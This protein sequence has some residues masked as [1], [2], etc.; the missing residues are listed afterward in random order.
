MSGGPRNGSDEFPS[1]TAAGLYAAETNGNG[2][3]WCLVRWQ[4]GIWLYRSRFGFEA[5]ASSPIGNCLF[6]AL[7]E[8]LYGDQSQHAQLRAAVVDH[9]KEHADQYKPFLAAIGSGNRKPKRKNAGALQTAPTPGE[10]N[11]QFRRHL[12]DM[13]RGG[14]YGDNME[15]Q[16]FANAF[17]VDVKIWHH[18]GQAWL[19]QSLANTQNARMVHIAY[20][21]S[22][23]CKT[24]IYIY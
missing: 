21:V 2:E 18:N 11:A 4:L 10:I 12:D 9:M 8:Q 1:L 7:S 15:V 16:A 13:A 23:L 19:L 3:C 14:T 22:P 6:H 17:G 24:F 5:N 20:H